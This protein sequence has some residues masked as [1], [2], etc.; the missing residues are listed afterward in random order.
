[1][2]HKHKCQIF[3]WNLSQ[4]GWSHKV[5]RQKRWKILYKFL[6]LPHNTPLLAKM[7]PIKYRVSANKIYLLT[8]RPVVGQRKRTIAK[9]ILNPFILM[10]PKTRFR[11]LMRVLKA[12]GKLLSRR[13]KLSWKR[14]SKARISKVF[15]QNRTCFYKILMKFKIRS[16]DFTKYKVEILL[17]SRRSMRKFNVAKKRKTNFQKID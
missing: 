12:K 10:R 15:W 2:N 14:R 5:N 11:S 8:K 13:S 6:A 4:Q 9:Q 17:N 1:M 16:I 7:I 3:N